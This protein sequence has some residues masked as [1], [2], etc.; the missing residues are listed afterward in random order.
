MDKSLKIPK[1]GWKILASV[2][3]FPFSMLF[4]KFSWYSD[5]LKT[6]DYPLYQ[7]II[8][9][10]IIPLLIVFWFSICWSLPTLIVSSWIGKFIELCR[11]I[12]RFND[13]SDVENCIKIYFTIGKGFGMYFLYVFG[14]SQIFAIFTF[15]MGITTMI[16]PIESFSLDISLAFGFFCFFFGLICSIIDFACILDD[17]YQAMTE[18][19]R[20]LQDRLLMIEEKFERQQIENLIRDIQRVGPL[21]GKGFFQ[22]TRG[23]LTGMLSVSVTYVIILIQFR[24]T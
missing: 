22:I 7:K 1:S 10:F 3:L 24:T 11:G 20:P 4:I 18:L 15:F 13:I 2:I 12:T 5:V 6:T 19:V 17:G 23:T 9:V 14:V 8:T 21:S 16:G